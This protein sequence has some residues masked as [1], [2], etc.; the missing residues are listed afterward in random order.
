MVLENPNYRDTARRLQKVLGATCGLDVGAD[1]VERAFCGD[2]KEEG[3]TAAEESQTCIP[4]GM[5]IV[6]V[7]PS[8]TSLRTS[9]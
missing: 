6:T 4:K 1:I 5:R 2:N 7:V 3:R 8:P 9:S